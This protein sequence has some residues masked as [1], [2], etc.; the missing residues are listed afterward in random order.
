MLKARSAE[1]VSAVER[2]IGENKEKDGTYSISFGSKVHE[3]V[4]SWLEL[5]P[6]IR[7]YSQ[8]ALALLQ[9]I[10]RARRPK[11][12]GDQGTLF[13]PGA[14]V[15]LDE[16]GTRVLMAEMTR[17]H[18]ERAL[19]VRRKAHEIEVADYVKDEAYW[20]ERMDAFDL[21]CRVLIDVEVRKFGYQREQDE[22]TSTMPI[23]E[24]ARQLIDGYFDS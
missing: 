8:E 21:Q 6:E 2:I 9:K 12:R 23:F 19:G 15:P 5:N 16:K 13:D 7:N 17:E 20:E 4:T 10:D 18:C 24:Q 11:R 3:E 1:I 14:M 22:P